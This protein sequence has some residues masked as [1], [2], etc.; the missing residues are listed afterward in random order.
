MPHHI[1]YRGV[2]STECRLQVSKSYGIRIAKLVYKKLIFMKKIFAIA[3]L[4][5]M[6][7]LGSC[8]KD[9]ICKCTDQDGDTEN[10]EQH[11]QKL[12]EARTECKGRDFDQTVL[13]VHTSQSC[14]LQ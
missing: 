5:S 11:D 14:S 4:S 12:T 1:S 2:F 10:F 8:K 3:S 7:F 13:G 9:W 6:L